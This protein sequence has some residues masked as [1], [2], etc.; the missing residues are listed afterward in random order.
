[1]PSATLEDQVIELLT[2]VDLPRDWRSQIQQLIAIPVNDGEADRQR[3]DREF[4]QLRKQHMWGFIGDDEIRREGKRI[5][6]ALADLAPPPAVD[7]YAAPV[8]LLRSVGQIVRSVNKHNSE[9][10]RL[11]FRRF[12]EVAFT[13]IE[14]EGRQVSSVEPRERYRE[15]FAVG[16]QSSV[17]RCA[18][19]RTSPCATPPFVLLPNDYAVSVAT[20]DSTLR[21]LCA[22]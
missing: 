1:V 13:R 6:R 10:G 14:I 16:L 3:L 11:L 18:V 20:L 19:K 5:K 4:E 22:A 15:I 2:K 7:A 8:Q 21:V 9:Q 17:V 12:C